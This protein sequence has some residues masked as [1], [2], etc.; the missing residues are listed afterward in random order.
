M[1]RVVDKW[2]ME[3]ALKLVIHDETEIK[4]EFKVHK[5]LAECEAARRLVVSLAPG[6]GLFTSVSALKWWGLLFETVG[7]PPGTG[8]QLI[9]DGMQLIRAFHAAGYVHGDARPA[10]MVRVGEELRFVD[11]ARAGPPNPDFVQSLQRED[12]ALFLRSALSLE[13]VRD[14]TAHDQMSKMA[15]DWYPALAAAFFEEKSVETLY[16]MIPRPLRER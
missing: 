5:T 7:K 10:N 14:S 15:H 11:V 1:F 8:Q 13:I 12:L 6:T 16:D 4:L 9:E 2:K 3:R